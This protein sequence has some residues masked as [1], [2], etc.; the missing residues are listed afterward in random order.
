MSNSYVLFMYLYQ[1]QNYPKE[2]KRLAKFLELDVTDE[3][4]EQIAIKGQINTVRDEL[5]KIPEIQAR[6]KTMTSD[7]TLPIYRKGVSTFTP[8]ILSFVH[9]YSFI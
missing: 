5:M 7:G 1:F 2:L 6:A 3:I 9:C 8:S 4:I